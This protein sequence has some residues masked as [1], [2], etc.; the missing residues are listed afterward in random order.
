MKKNISNEEIMK[1]AEEWAA[2]FTF[3]EFSKMLKE[4]IRFSELD[5]LNSSEWLENSSKSEK[6]SIHRYGTMIIKDEGKIPWTSSGE[7]NKNKKIYIPNDFVGFVEFVEFSFDI[8]KA[9]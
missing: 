4:E 1:K 9:A 5:D 8:G 3:D 7:Y 2:S 6:V